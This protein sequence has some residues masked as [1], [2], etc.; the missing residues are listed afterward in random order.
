[1]ADEIRQMAS[2]AQGSS[3][4]SKASYEF[5]APENYIVYASVSSKT[6]RCPAAHNVDPGSKH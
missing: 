5:E 6:T 3:Y 1:M 4:L 2:R